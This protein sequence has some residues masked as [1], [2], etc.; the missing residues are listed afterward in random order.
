MST[1]FAYLFNWH[2]TQANGMPGSP[3]RVGQRANQGRWRGG[4]ASQGGESRNGGR[5]PGERGWGR[6]A[7]R[8][9]WLCGVPGGGQ[10]E[11]T[12]RGEGRLA[13]P[14]VAEGGRARPGEQQ[15]PAGGPRREAPGRAATLPPTS[16]PRASQGPEGVDGV[17]LAADRQWPGERSA[18]V[19]SSSSVPSP[20]RR[21]PGDPLGDFE[22]PANL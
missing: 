20:G 2:S 8:G 12:P 17:P 18:R 10:R 9:V 6:S 1:S 7:L 22:G 21:R 14:S 4:A 11:R 16:P 19:A 5:G 13:G 3:S 15:V